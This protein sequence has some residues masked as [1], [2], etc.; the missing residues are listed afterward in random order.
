MALRHR[1]RTPW[2]PLIPAEKG[3]LF[4]TRVEPYL[5]S[6]NSVHCLSIVREAFVRRSASAVALAIAVLFLTSSMATAQPPTFA[7]V[8]PTSALHGVVVS[9]ISAD[10]VVGVLVASVEDGSPA[11]KAGLGP[12][13]II[14]IVVTGPEKFD[15][16]R[17]LMRHPV[18]FY[19]AAARCVP[20]CLVQYLRG[21]VRGWRGVGTL[22]TNI[23]AATYGTNME[24]IL[25]PQQMSGVMWTAGLRR[26]RQPP[27]WADKRE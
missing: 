5:Y 4:L 6:N 23:T 10:A 20:D 21:E 9:V 3:R 2:L 26:M 19:A 11:Q 1:M 22:G 12:G 27:T 13:D 24:P 25:S 15:P 17:D 14:R 18:Y 7:S 16:A 8:P